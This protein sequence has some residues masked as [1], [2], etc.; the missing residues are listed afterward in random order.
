MIA[1]DYARTAA[2]DVEAIL[3]RY[4]AESWHRDVLRVRMACLKCANGDLAL[5]AGCIEEANRDYRD[6][7]AAAE[8][9]RYDWGLDEQARAAAIARDWQEL[10][11]WLHR[12]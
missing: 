7:L 2:R 5:L 11:D 9:R 3:A 4:G 12:R 1:R 8:Y 10:Q 6:V